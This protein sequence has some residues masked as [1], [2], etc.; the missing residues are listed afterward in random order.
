MNCLDDFKNALHWGNSFRV[1]LIKSKPP[2][3]LVLP[4]ILVTSVRIDRQR[5][6]S[7]DANPQPQMT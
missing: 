2:G 1:D 3:Y 4:A 6:E 5:F 7:V